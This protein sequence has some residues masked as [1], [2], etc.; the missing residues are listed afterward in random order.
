[1]GRQR[2]DEKTETRRVRF[3]F[4]S[5]SNPPTLT[6]AAFRSES[7]VVD[8]TSLAALPSDAWL[9]LTLPC[10]YVTMAIGGTQRMAVAPVEGDY[11]SSDNKKNSKN[12]RLH[13]HLSFEDLRGSIQAV[14][15]TSPM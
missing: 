9:T 1:M 15:L 13:L 4:P 8:L 5:F 11:I 10:L 14:S 2:E 6:F 12:K 3:R 7:E